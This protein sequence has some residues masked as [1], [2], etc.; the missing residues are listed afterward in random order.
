MDGKF[1][2]DSL[3]V[4]SLSYSRVW[5]YFTPY[6]LPHHRIQRMLLSKQKRTTQK[7]SAEESGRADHSFRPAMRSSTVNCQT[8]WSPS[9][10][11]RS[12]QYPCRN[13]ALENGCAPGPSRLCTADNIIFISCTAITWGTSKYLHRFYS[14]CLRRRW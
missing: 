14:I 4:R 1:Q 6:K 5:G 10:R 7:S 3:L 13:K 11:S 8:G 2:S 9:S 12:S